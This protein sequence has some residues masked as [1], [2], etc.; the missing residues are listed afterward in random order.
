M[1]PPGVIKI[2][3]GSYRNDTGIYKWQQRDER[4]RLH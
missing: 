2:N 3:T 1:T 4:R